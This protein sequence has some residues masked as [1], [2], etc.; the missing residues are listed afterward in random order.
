ML[1][2]RTFLDYTKV[3]LCFMNDTRSIKSYILLLSEFFAH[4]Y[5]YMELVFRAFYNEQHNFYY[6]NDVK[7][8]NEG[9]V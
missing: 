8:L 9:M 1:T 6:L 5:S 2:P 3:Y 7:G 4:I